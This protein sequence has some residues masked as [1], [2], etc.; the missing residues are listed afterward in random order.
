MYISRESC[1]TVKQKLEVRCSLSA[2][3]YTNALVKLV[4]DLEAYAP[5]DQ[6]HIMRHL[7]DVTS[8]AM[9]R[10]WA[11]VRKW[12]QAVFD[13]IEQG[14]LTWADYQEIQ[15]LRFRIAHTGPAMSSSK[16]Q[17]TGPSNNEYLCRDFNSRS[18]CRHR[19]DHT[20]GSVKILHLCAFCDAVQ[21]QCIHNVIACDRKLTYSVNRQ[22]RPQQQVGT[23]QFPPSRS[24]YI[25]Q[26]QYQYYQPK[27]G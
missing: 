11:T 14:D 8:D 2:L 19:G 3:E 5:T 22:Y 25:E 18:G 6:P 7:R 9:E 23:Q 16:L 13:G 20:D 4:M 27:N 21:K 1:Q 15:N 24:Q 10:P 26:Q 12:S 17:N